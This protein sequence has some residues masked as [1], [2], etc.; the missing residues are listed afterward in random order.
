[1]ISPPARCA[2][3]I[4]MESGDADS[5][6]ANTHLCLFHAIRSDLTPP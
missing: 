6:D 3:I 5:D 4:G 1:M 2:R